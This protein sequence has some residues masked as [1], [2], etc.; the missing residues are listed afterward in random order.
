MLKNKYENK[1]RMIGAILSYVFTG[2]NL[3]VNFIYAPILLK[4]MGKSEYGLYQMVASFFAYIT[5]FETSLSTGVLRYYCNA[6]A[7]GNEIEIENVLSISRRI[8]RIMSVILAFAGALLIVGY[9]VFY[10]NSLSYSQ[11]K[12]SILM[13]S[14]LIVNMIISMLNSVYLATITGNE[15]FVFVQSVRIVIQIIQPL[16]CCLAVIK[17]PYALTIVIG[18]LVVNIGAAIIRR[19][20]AKKS[21]GIKI[22]AH[23]RD[24]K[25]ARAILIFA[26]SLLLSAIADQIFW[27]ADQI[28]IGKM[29]N[30]ILVAVYSIGGQIYTCYQHVG[31]S[32]SSVF[33]PKLSNL[34]QEDDGIN[35]MSDLFIRVGRIVFLVLLIVLTGFAIFGREF[36]GYWVGNEYDD[37]YYVAIFVMVPFTIDLVQNLGLSILQIMNRYS[38]RAKVYFVAALINIVTTVILAKYMGIKGAAFSTGLSMLITSGFILNWYYIKLGLKI[39]EFWINIAGILIKLLPYTIIMYFLNLW[40]SNMTGG[41]GGLILRMA[42]YSCGYV[43][44]AFLIA[45]NQYEKTLIRNVY[46][47]IMRRS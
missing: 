46:K 43:C 29:Y 7:K 41:M 25:L 30:T 31:T 21:I 13:L 8:Y 14:V 19:R 35:K 12:E 26:S 10:K 11:L 6:K 16:I 33:Y 4:Y 20:Y 44:V 38:F 15:K 18:Q 23:E 40:I 22:V 3:I 32:M 39:K 9:I 36:L 45:M 27:K 24:G 17:F 47:K 42:I 28:I 2:L 1:E 5:I 34:Y 37:A